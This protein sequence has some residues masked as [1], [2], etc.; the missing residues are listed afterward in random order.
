MIRSAEEAAS[1]WTSDALEIEGG[2]ADLAVDVSVDDDA[3]RAAVAQRS[4]VAKAFTIPIDVDSLRHA[5]D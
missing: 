5:I 2:D 1:L 3:I 4:G